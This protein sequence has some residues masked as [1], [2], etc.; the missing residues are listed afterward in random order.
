MVMIEHLFSAEV[1]NLYFDVPETGGPTLLSWNLTPFYVG[2][3]QLLSA[4]IIFSSLA[5]SQN[6]SQKQIRGLNLEIYIQL[7]K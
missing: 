2:L 6:A 7:F 1:R 4:S 3:Y 5:Q